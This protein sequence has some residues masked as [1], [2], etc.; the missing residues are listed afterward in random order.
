METI[1]V[2]D[3]EITLLQK[4]I[5]SRHKSNHAQLSLLLLLLLF[6][7][8]AYVNKLE[9]ALQKFAVLCFGRFFLLVH[10][11]AVY[12]LDH[13]KL[14]RFLYEEILPQWTIPHSSIPWL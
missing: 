12:A 4:P 3:L 6:I 13:L 2:D 5:W 7:T 9:R 11:N 10:Y 8:S 1:D 14:Q